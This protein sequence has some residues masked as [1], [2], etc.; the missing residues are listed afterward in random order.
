MSETFKENDVQV[1]TTAWHFDKRISLDN[2]ILIICY[3]TTVIWFAAD[4]NSRLKN[5]EE[6]EPMLAVIRESRPQTMLRIQML[7]QNQTAVNAFLERM[8]KLENEV[9]NLSATVSAQSSVIN[10]IDLKISN[11]KD[12]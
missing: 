2:G 6:W 4:A 3:I 9:S 12:Q 11:T 5:M 10:R 1:K 8:L 7:E